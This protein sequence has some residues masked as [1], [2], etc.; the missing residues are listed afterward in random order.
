M[1]TTYSGTGTASAENFGATLTAYNPHLSDR[2]NNGSPTGNYATECIPKSMGYWL[3]LLSLLSLLV[4]LLSAPAF[5]ITEAQFIEKVLA[6]DQ[7]LE[8]AQIGLDIKQ[9]ELDASRDNY[10]NWKS[11]LYF[12]ADYRYQDI[13]RETTSKYTYTKNRE[14]YPKEIGV[15]LEKRFLS[16]PGSLDLGISRSRDKDT[17][18]RYKKLVHQPKSDYHTKKDTTEG[19]IRYTYPLLKH[20]SNAASLKTHHRDIIDLKRQKLLFY[21]TNEDFLDDRLTDY[22]SWVLYQRRDFIDREFLDKFQRLD[23][24]DEAEIALLKTT[25]YQIE[26]DNSDTRTRLR[27]IREKL[28]SLLKDRTILTETAQFDLH[29]RADLVANNLPGYLET[30]NRTL[31]RINLN[32]ALSQIEIEYYQN[33]NLPTLDLDLEARRTLSQGNT[34][35][36]VYEDDKTNYMIGLEFRY[37]L[38]GNISTRANLKKSRLGVRKLEISYQEK[39]Q[40]ILADIR[41]LDTLLTWDEAQMLEA[42]EAA[43]QSTA[44]EYQNYQSGQTSFRDLLQAYK[45]ERIAR[46]DHSEYLI[47]YQTNRIEYDNLLDRI[48]QSPCP[49]PLSDCA[50]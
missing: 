50:Y 46:L 43:A 29:K 15:S 36:S 21:E 37:P 8:E 5:A 32:I 19:Y 20:D 33:Q 30:R 10:Q 3:C 49:T 18:I 38:G 45:D 35:S 22:L 14:Q 25:V 41:L 24:K 26:A 17:V 9:I 31:E 12:D 13:H 28:S 7:L 42:I 40:D 27:A 2:K 1:N 6:Q 23:A 34:S 44:I 48:I 16:N 39:L 4:P 47:D 11:V